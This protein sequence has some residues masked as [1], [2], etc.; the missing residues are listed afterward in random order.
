MT[1]SKAFEIGKR[2]GMRIG[3]AYG[4]GIGML[5]AILAVILVKA[6]GG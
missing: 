2:Y 6:F 1:I 5:G 3:F 4:V